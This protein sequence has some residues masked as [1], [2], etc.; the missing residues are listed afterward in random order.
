[1]A[2]KH[3]HFFIF[4]ILDSFSLSFDN[5]SPP[6]SQTTQRSHVDFQIMKKKQTN[7]LTCSPWCIGMLFPNFKFSSQSWQA[8]VKWIRFQKNYHVKVDKTTKIQSHIFHI[9]YFIHLVF[10]RNAFFWRKWIQ[11]YHVWSQEHTL[12]LCAYVSESHFLYELSVKCR[13]EESKV[14][15]HARVGG[16]VSVAEMCHDLMNKMKLFQCLH[17]LFGNFLLWWWTF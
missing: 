16:W 15:K 4:E 12:H 1:M 3:P 2:R 7:T 6:I 10:N 9:S 11:R 17:F 13:T 14:K 5:W 8:Y